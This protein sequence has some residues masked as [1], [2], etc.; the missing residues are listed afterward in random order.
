M[1]KIVVLAL[2]AA[3]LSLGACNTIAG[4][5]KDASAAGQAVTKTA[6]DAKPK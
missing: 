3:A 2:A 4:F 1:R 6:E 5:G